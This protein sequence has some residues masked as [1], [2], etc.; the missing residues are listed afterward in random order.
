MKENSKRRILIV[1]IIAIVV[2]I[3]VVAAIIVNGS[4][5]KNNLR[6]QLDLAEQYLSDL[7]YEQAIAAYEQALEIEPKCEAAYLGLADIYV[8]LEDYDNALEILNE[9]YE[10]TGADS[11][12]EKI[13]EIQNLMEEQE[14]AEEVSEAETEQDIM[15]QQDTESDDIDFDYTFDITTVD[16]TV[17]GKKIYEWTAEEL[18]QYICDTGIYDKS[19][20]TYNSS[21]SGEKYTT[22]S[23]E[24]LGYDAERTVEIAFLE[25][26]YLLHV[27]VPEDD[28]GWVDVSADVGIYDATD[29]IQDNIMGKTLY[30]FLGNEDLVDAL[31]RQESLKCINAD[32]SAYFY[33]DDDLRQVNIETRSYSD[34]PYEII[35]FV[36]DNGAIDGVCFF[37]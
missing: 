23:I 25:S 8:T 3:L 17:Y 11:I 7:D 22:Y 31:Q 9:G 5:S 34:D 6:D 27:V 18:M 26:N 19:A 36:D 37:Y 16:V 30:D 1:S 14:K 29:N 35:I 12:A 20:E 2:V 33:N 32:I 21:L 15:A 13:E 28:G 10:Q 4:G 24:N